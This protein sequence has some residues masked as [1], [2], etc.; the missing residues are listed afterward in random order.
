MSGPSAGGDEGP[1]DRPA[2]LDAPAHRPEPRELAEALVAAQRWDA[3][4]AALGPE[5]AQRPDDAQLRALLVRALRATGRRQEALDAAQQLLA[6]DPHDPYALRLGTLVLLDVGWVDE[7]IGLATRAVASDAHNP[8]NHLALSRAWAASGRPGAVEHQLAAARE[9]L[10]LDPQSID[11]QLQIGTALARAGDLP[12]ARDAY[13]AALSLDP[14]NSAALNN[15]AVLDLRSGAHGAA[16]RHLAAALA[17]DPQDRV[18]RRNLDATAVRV[19][20]RAGWWLVLTPLPALL[21]AALGWDLVAR[22][23]AAAALLGTPGLLLWWWRALSTGQRRH[24]RSLRRRLR[25]RT[26]VW[27]AMAMLVGLVGLAAPLLTPGQVTTATVRGYA[28][29]VVGL[30]VVRLLVA[31][32]RPTWRAELA[33]RWARIGGR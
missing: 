6:R 23:A 25:W 21:A 12:G 20:G 2:W 9:A 32:A 33:A 28:L 30:S 31:S 24:L 7:A 14:G 11:A 27:P 17:A 4:L 19:L 22:A 16:A 3:A 29:V 8:A 5:L 26:W 15:L 13:R 18:A 10:R 1:D